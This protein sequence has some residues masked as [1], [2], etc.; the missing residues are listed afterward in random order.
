MIKNN[1]NKNLITGM[2]RPPMYPLPGPG[3][4][5]HPVFPDFAQ[6]LQ[7]YSDI[8]FDINLL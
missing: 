3:Q 5:S 7:W 2:P 8:D 6:T 4:Y 1:E